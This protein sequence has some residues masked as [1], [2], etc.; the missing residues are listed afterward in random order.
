MPAND[1]WDLIRRLKGQNVGLVVRIFPATTRTFTKDT[2]PSEHG[3]GAA[4]RVWINGTA[5]QGNGM[6]TACY[7]WIGLNAAPLPLLQAVPSRVTEFFVRKQS[8]QSAQR[9]DRDNLYM[10]I[11]FLLVRCSWGKRFVIF[12]HHKNEWGFQN[13]CHYLFA[14][15]LQDSKSFHGI[16]PELGFCQH[17]CHRSG[18]SPRRQMQS[19]CLPHQLRKVHPITYHDVPEGEYRHS[20]TLL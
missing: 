12:V 13:H 16:Q 20:S 15:V 17:H 8:A 7:V 4:W 2:A 3:R 6:G 14:G 9:L 11:C 10:D 1:R 19:T 5:W 18:Y